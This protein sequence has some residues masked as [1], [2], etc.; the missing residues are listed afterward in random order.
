[1]RTTGNWLVV[2]AVLHG[3]L[4]IGGSP[5]AA[6]LKTC[7]TSCP[8]DEE[9]GHGHTG[10]ASHGD[11]DCCKHAEHSEAA[12]RDVVTGGFT[13]QDGVMRTLDAPGLGV[14]VI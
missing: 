10:A 5:A 14:T 8:C 12:P 1:M 3:P 9:R 11:Y 13:L 6:T 4:G 7:G 2:V